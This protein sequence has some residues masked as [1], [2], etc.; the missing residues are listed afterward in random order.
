MNGII[1]IIS[2]TYFMM[3]YSDKLLYAQTTKYEI[4]DIPSQKIDAQVFKKK[5][6]IS[7]D[8]LYNKSID[9]IEKWDT[10]F[11]LNNQNELLY[12]YTLG[13]EGH[14]HEQ[15]LLIRYEKESKRVEYI[16]KPNSKLVFSHPIKKVLSKKNASAFFKELKKLETGFFKQ[17]SM[18][19]SRCH[20]Q[21]LIHKTN[22]QIEF[23]LFNFNEFI[24]KNSDSN[25]PTMLSRDFHFYIT[26]FF[27]YGK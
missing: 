8:M 20:Y 11:S 6:D 13:C 26:S 4:S 2:I 19:K 18:L 12:Y 1:K 10:V 7:I 25:Y 9:F 14:F 17:T 24:F 22:E 5:Q 23:G 27:P 16:R 15:L 3:I 21:V